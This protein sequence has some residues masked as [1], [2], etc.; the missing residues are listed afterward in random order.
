MSQTTE[1]KR[2]RGFGSDNHSGVHPQILSA[3][4]KANEGHVPAYG[5]DSYT[6]DAVELFRSLTT[7]KAEA[8]FVFNGT[9]A[10]I[11]S[12]SALVRSHHSVLSSVQSHLVNDECGAFEKIVGAKVVLVATPDGKLTPEL[13]K[14]HLIRRGDQHASQV[15][16]ITIT[17]QTEIG[18]VYSLDEIRALRAFADANDLRLHLDG[19]RL[20]N[21]AV[22]LGCGLGDIMNLCDVVSF[23]GTKNSLMFGEAVVFPHG[24]TDLDFKYSRKQFMQLPSKTRFVAAQFLEY[25][26]TDLWLQNARHSNAMAARLSEGLARSKYAKLTQ[27]TQANGCFVLLPK[28]LVSKLREHYF[29]YVWDEHTFECRLMTS[30]DTTADDVDGFLTVL[31]RLGE[32]MN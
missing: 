20:V 23:G 17:Q 10:N 30:W 21:A 12:L 11:L 32:E 25:L 16:A 13:L 29:F 27:K 28:K 1:Q 15:K 2:T 26:G 14:P 4:V 5:T 7:S 3:I 22:S 9:A 6:L 18:T 19:A 8:F 24:L 31:E